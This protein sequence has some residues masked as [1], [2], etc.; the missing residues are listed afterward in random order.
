MKK[1]ILL[2]SILLIVIFFLMPIHQSFAEPIDTGSIGVNAANQSEFDNLGSVIFGVVQGVGIGISVI[3][4]V[5]IG[6]KYIIGSV[7]EKAELKS[8]MI[9]YI[10]GAIF[11][12]GATTIPNLIYNIAI[13]IQP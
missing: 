12:A 3:V 13:T 7:D 8:S 9:P 1:R 11:L 2:I 5:I 4:L 10:I 6:I